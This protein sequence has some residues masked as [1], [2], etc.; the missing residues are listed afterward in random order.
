MTR[1]LHITAVAIGVALII[2]APVRAGTYDV[3]ACADAGT[4][5]NNSWAMSNSSNARLESAGNCGAAGDYAGLYVRDVVGVSNAS[6]GASAQW[7][8]SAPAGTTITHISYS[9]WLFKDADDDWQPSVTAD[10]TTIDTCSIVY[11]AV[12]CNSGSKGGGR[13][14]APVRDATTVALAVRCGATA[15]I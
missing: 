8:F 15:P 10:S 2:A 9:R 6:A 13:S 14:A 3:V 5:A 7:T 1:T 11:P 4:G 12:D